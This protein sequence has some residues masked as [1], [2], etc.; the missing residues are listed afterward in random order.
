MKGKIVQIVN[1]CRNCSMELLNSFHCLEND[2]RNLI[3]KGIGSL[4]IHQA[5]IS[6]FF[7]NYCHILFK[8]RKYYQN[9]IGS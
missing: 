4:Q 9:L 3:N 5:V 7:Q 8:V 1:Y 6:A 2:L